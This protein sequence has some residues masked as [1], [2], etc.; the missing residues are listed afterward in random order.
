[1]TKSEA[2]PKGDTHPEAD[3]E[4]EPQMRKT[5]FYA[6]IHAPRHQRQLIIKEIQRITGRKVIC[7]VSG[8]QA[9]VDRDD[10]PG[11]VDLLHNIAPNV[12]L[13]LV[14]HTGGGDIDAA[15]KLISMV[16]TKVGTGTLRAVV[17]DYAKSAGTLIALGAD[18][19]VMSDMSE[20]GPIDPQISLADG[21]GNRI[22]H[23][24]QSYLDAYNEYAE[25]LK[26]DPDSVLARLMLSKL[27]PGT[28]KLYRAVRNRAQRFA[29]GYLRQ[30]M[31]RDKGNFTA[32]AAALIDTER[33]QSHGQMISWQAAQS[34]D[35]GLVVEYLQPLDE[36]WQLYWQLYC[37]QRLAVR[38]RQK[39]FESDFVSIVMD[40][41][42]S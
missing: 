33:W 15:E 40:S 6:A 14:L 11:F 18:R 27:D 4:S 36:V 23:P 28:I 17:P 38:D 30:G 2:D 22:L 31:L 21:N 9:A 39:L 1:M 8:P 19:I 3:G 25:M 35:I 5:P 34:T 42:L 26:T 29:E 16:R 41:S 20:L 7:Y 32:A 37:H 10:T 12:D 24:I 13:D